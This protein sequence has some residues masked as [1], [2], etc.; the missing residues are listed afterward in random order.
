MASTEMMHGRMDKQREGDELELNQE[1]EI[2]K[3]QN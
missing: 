1:S 3:A 2:R